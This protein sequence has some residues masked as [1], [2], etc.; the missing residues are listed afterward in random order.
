MGNPPRSILIVMMSA[1]GDAVQVLPVVNALK[2]AFPRIH[3][4]WLIQPLP[5]SL[6]ADHPAVDEFVIFRR[7]SRRK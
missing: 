1:I 3:I 2:R 4:T 6:V 7:G 5:H